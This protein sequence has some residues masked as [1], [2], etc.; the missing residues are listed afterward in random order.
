LVWK[1]KRVKRSAKL[2]TGFAAAL[3]SIIGAGTLFQASE[4]RAPLPVFK[5]IEYANFS[6]ERNKLDL[7]LPDSKFANPPLV[8][9]IHGGGWREGDKDFPV[10]AKRL[11]KEGFAVASINYRLSQ[12]AKWPA[13]LED[14]GAAIRMLRG[15]GGRLGYDGSRIALF[16]ASAGGHLAATAGLAFS[17]NP[18]ARVSAVVDWYGPTDLTRLDADMAALGRTSKAGPAAE[19]SSSASQLIGVSVAKAPSQAFAA[20]PASY[21]ATAKVAP[22]PYL[23]MH[24]DADD[25]VAPAQSARFHKQL[26]TQFGKDSAAYILVHGGTHGKGG[27]EGPA[28]QTRVVNFLKAT[29]RPLESF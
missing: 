6:P 17:A 24:G 21:V 22:P 5:D 10:A 28:V 14:V 19:V 23:I 26:T 29:L 4:A 2:L 9:W 11:L 16:G 7:Y 1:R 8:V 15:N 20:S 12:Q 27:F 13:Q 3:V 25:Y 18:T